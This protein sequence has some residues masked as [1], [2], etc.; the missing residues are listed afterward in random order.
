M[1]SKASPGSYGSDEATLILATDRG[2]KSSSSSSWVILPEPLVDPGESQI[3][4]EPC[5][6]MSVV[7]R[8]VLDPS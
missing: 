6:G 5:Y 7:G 1:T 4:K 2:R 8:V 3:S